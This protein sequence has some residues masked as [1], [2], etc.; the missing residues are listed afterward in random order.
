MKKYIDKETGKIINSID[1]AEAIQIIGMYF[2]HT[3]GK[4]KMNSAKMK[5]LTYLSTYMKTA[6]KADITSIIEYLESKKSQ[7]NLN[8]EA[9][10]QKYTTLL[11]LF[12]L[13]LDLNS[14]EIDIIRAY[15]VI[16]TLESTKESIKESKSN[17]MELRPKETMLAE[18]MDNGFEFKSYAPEICKKWSDNLKS[19]MQN[20]E[21]E[22]SLD[23][24]IAYQ[25]LLDFNIS[26]TSILN[27]SSDKK[28]QNKKTDVKLQ[29][30]VKEE[31]F[32]TKTEEL[33]KEEVHEEP[34]EQEVPEI[35]VTVP[36]DKKVEEQV[37]KE[38]KIQPEQI[39]KKTQEV[40]L[41]ESIDF[42]NQILEDKKD[43]E[44]KPAEE[45]SNNSEEDDNIT[46]STGNFSNIFRD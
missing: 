43:K 9:S 3:F 2:E 23:E 10:S 45:S 30:E 18:L 5:F 36:E 17:G 28:V 27:K 4:V 33:K 31:K 6:T 26:D 46:E 12:R 44:K 29:E 37:K 13:Y 34:K 8:D 25:D 21:V 15:Q 11:K 38:E 14:D 7:I 42:V 16:A 35:V 22:V 1:G 41:K 20:G 19:K 40:D 32:E 39:S 24:E